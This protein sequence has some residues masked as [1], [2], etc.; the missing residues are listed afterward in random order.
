MKESVIEKKLRQAA[1][2]KVKRDAVFRKK[3]K[4]AEKEN[5]ADIQILN[6]I[7]IEDDGDV[8]VFHGTC[9]LSE[10]IPGGM[11]EGIPHSFTMRMY[12]NSIDIEPDSL[13]IDLLER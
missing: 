11:R 3:G 6:N 12:V 5:V 7:E 13:S 2:D 1:L 8:I 4:I 9:N 10:P